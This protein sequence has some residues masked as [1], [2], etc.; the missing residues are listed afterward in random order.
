M[1]K[2]AFVISACMAAAACS[3]TT[4]GAVG[5]AATGALVGGP[6]GALVG[7]GIGAAAGSA[8]DPRVAQAGPG[9]CYV[10]DQR[11]RRLN[12]AYGRP[13]TRAC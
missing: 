1:Y 11:N 2:L 9:Q 13:M 5:G 10:Y 8:S 6:V 3:P 4:T 12:D 7:G